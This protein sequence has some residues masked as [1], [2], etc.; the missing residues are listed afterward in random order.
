LL[1]VDRGGANVIRGEPV[2]VGTGVVPVGEHVSTPEQQDGDSRGRQ[3]GSPALRPR[4][5]F[6][7]CE[8]DEVG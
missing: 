6:P 7:R 2:R 8:I 4:A 5:T 1:E 3:L